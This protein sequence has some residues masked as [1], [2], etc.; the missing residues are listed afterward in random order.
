MEFLRERMR[1]QENATGNCHPEKD[2]LKCIYTDASNFGAA[3]VT[4][5]KMNKLDKIIE[6]KMPKPMIFL[7]RTFSG[8]QRNW[9]SYEKKTHDV[10][11]TLD[12]VNYLF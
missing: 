7:G 6:M 10:V 3:V 9:K 12:F 4:H 1:K 8:A 11:E 5:T 2:H